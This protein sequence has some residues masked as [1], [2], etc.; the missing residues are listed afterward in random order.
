[1]RRV[2]GSTKG[3]SPPCRTSDGVVVRGRLT[4]SSVPIPF[5][6]LLLLLFLFFVLHH[7]SGAR[8]PTML[9][10]KLARDVYAVKLGRG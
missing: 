1:M 9:W 4:K 7:E 2:T 6:L 8:F 10:D 3:L 5:L